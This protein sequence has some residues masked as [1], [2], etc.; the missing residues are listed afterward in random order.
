MGGQITTLDLGYVQKAN[1]MTYIHQGIPPMLIQHGRRDHV[2]PW[3][4]SKIFVDKIREVC[5][6]DRVEY[7]ILNTA[8]HAD[9]H[10]K[11]KENMETVFTFLERHI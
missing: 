8:D 7:E 2:V 11:S 1:P 3:Q 9:R 4:Q 6:N 5:G 10:F